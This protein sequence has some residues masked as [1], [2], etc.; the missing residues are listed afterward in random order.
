MDKAI[1][2]TMKA[3]TEEEK[4][5]LRAI[6]E[7]GTAEWYECPCGWFYSG[8]RCPD[9]NCKEWTQ[10]NG[11][12]RVTLYSHSDKEGGYDKGQK[13]GLEGDALRRFASWGY[14][15]VFEADVN[16]ETGDVALLTVNGHKIFPV[17]G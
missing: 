7:R 13:L 3:N 15:L 6:L 8:V 17:K 9:K 5:A 16:L 4:V 11:I 2:V 12:R 14:E 10:V 1:M